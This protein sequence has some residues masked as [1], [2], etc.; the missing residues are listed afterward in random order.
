[1]ASRIG[2]LLSQM[3]LAEK[4]GQL[5]QVQGGEYC[6]DL[7]RQG[8]IGSVLNV[9]E[10]DTPNRA[11]VCNDLQRV[12]VEESRLGIPL[13]IGRDVIHGFR[14]IL[15]IPLGQA[16]SF[17]LALVEQGAAGAA[18]EASAVGI[19]WTF[20]PM[21]DIARD[22][23]WGR[24]AE[25]GGED[26]LLAGRLGA[27]MVRGFQGDD[28]SAPDRIA[29]CAKHYAGY[30]AAE[31]GRDYNATWIPEVLLRNVY[32]PPFR[33]CVEAGVATVM[34][35]FNDL[36]GVPATG[37]PF[38]LRQ[39]LRDEWDFAGLVVSDWDSVRELIS[40]GVAADEAEAARL[41]LTAGVDMEMVSDCYSRLSALI[42]TRTV[43]EALVDEAVSRVLGLKFCLGLFEAPYC[44]E[45]RASVH[46]DAN[47]LEV[48]KRLAT[49]SCVLLK[50]DGALPLPADV[51]SLACVGPLA[52]APTDQAGCWSMDLVPDDT[53]TPLVALREALA[54]SAEVCYAPGLDHARST[55]TGG[56]EAA[57][58]AAEDSDA[59]V[60]FL[61]EDAGLSG[62]AHCRAFLDLPGAQEQLLEALA[63][64]GKPIIAVVM[65]GR[66][67]VLSRAIDRVAALLIAWHPG[68]MGGP[69]LAD[70][71]LG[72]AS[73]SGKLPVSFPRTVGQ[74]PVYYSHMNTGRPVVPGG[75]DIPLGTP[76]DPVG[77]R[78]SY[79]DAD[80]RPLFPFGFGL[81]YTT[82]S[83]S[84]LVLSRT[85][86][87]PGECLVASVALTNAGLVEAEEVV[88]LYVRDLVGSVTRPLKELKDF[89]RVRLGAGER[90]IVSFELSTDALAF[91]NA[92]MER[93]VEPGGFHLMIGG[94]SDDVLTAEFSVKE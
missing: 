43:G 14:T 11:R 76:L 51:R 64:T 31:G 53:V 37:N 24:I 56:F 75:E 2:D 33:A 61:G 29:A 30:G 92:A 23:R 83:Y 9:T 20:A 8:L 72:R 10:P 18:R 50:N 89:R 58:G 80:T 87:S 60:V 7:A 12:A 4:L 62:E 32:L 25:G 44:D 22:P 21:V 6:Q 49:E 26:P 19:R 42:E 81:S 73:P 41:A 17:D 69:A 55:D 36:N 66:P 54:G 82:F 15:P 93:V 91:H 1:M 48:A 5:R 40:Q 52:H 35:A 28:L 39:I 88:Q 90:E 57:R 79:L 68:T 13:L 16:A 47:H 63:E 70:L 65:T 84:D 77:F 85:S 34:S 67:L 74:V 38:L 86:M 45:A 78:S 59:V 71:L 3:T 94:S 46:L 27:A